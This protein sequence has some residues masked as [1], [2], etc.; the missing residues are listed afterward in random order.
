M[1]SL[2]ARFFIK[3]KDDYNDPDTRGIYGV[4]CGVAGIILN[5][6]LFGIKLFAGIVS[7]SIAIT[8]DAMNNLSDAGS[9][10]ITLIGFRLAGQKPDPDHPFGHGRLEYI[11]GLLVSVVIILMA[12]ELM[13][14]SVTKIFHPEAVEC[15]YIILSILVI[16]ILIKIYMAYFNKSYGEKI[17][18]AALLATSKDSLSDS[19]AT[20]VVL[21]S[22]LIAYFSGIN[23]DGYCGVLVSLFVFFAG[24]GA[25]KD[26]IGPLLGQ[27]PEEEFVDNIEKIVMAKE[28]TDLGVIGIHDL[29]V[30]DY[31]PGRVMISLHVEVPSTGNIMELHDL[32]DNIE[33]DLARELN[34]QA[35]IHMDPVCVGDPMT[36]EL[37]GYSKD[38]I[39]LLNEK[40]DV[41]L[42]FHDFR[43]V[44]GPT[45]TN[46]IFDIVLPYDF[47]MTENEVTEYIQNKI[48]EKNKSIFVRINYD[49]EFAKKR[50]M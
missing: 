7:S 42:S 20:S 28:H 24:Y 19:V 16:S 40:Y 50:G 17:N 13:K 49:R 43:I 14:S 10:I 2:L 34:C 27:P 4:L 29:V 15:N 32:I 12:W 5:V 35:T 8:A 45:H 38:A 33:V 22:T 3:N 48:W 26:T 41:K 39:G 18:S 1:V 44:A 23:V 37:K 25:A 47:P 6:F 11:S 30:H 31:G 36:D 46:V 21:I 9:S